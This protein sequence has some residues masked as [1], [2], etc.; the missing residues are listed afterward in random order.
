MQDFIKI[1]NE[2]IPLEK[3]A[4]TIKNKNQERLEFFEKR[5]QEIDLF[6]KDIR[7]SIGNLTAEVYAPE[8][9]EVKE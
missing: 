5:I 6:E 4:I 9:L 3:S 1:S 2:I 8:I 7:N